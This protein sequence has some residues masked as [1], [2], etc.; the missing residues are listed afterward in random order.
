MGSTRTTDLKFEVVVIPVGDADR[1]KEF[2]GGL[3]WRLDADFG[4]DNGFRVIQFTPPGSGLSVQFGARMT[5]AE[6]GSAQGLYL[7]SATSRPLGSSCA[8]VG[9]R[10]ARR[11]TPASRVRSSSPRATA[12]GS[13]ALSPT[14]RATAHSRRSAT[15]TATAGCCRK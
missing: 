1:A 4:F 12:A 8:R 5:S 15:R 10:S 13:A 3:G 14:T 7:S 2:Y 6:P 11:S 9:P